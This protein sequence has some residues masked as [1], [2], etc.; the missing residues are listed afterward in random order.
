MS[1][2]LQACLI[3]FP[4]FLGGHMLLT[5]A[6]LVV[7]LV[8][9]LPL[10]IWASRW[11]LVAELALGVSGI[12]QTIPGLALLALMVPLLHGTIGFLPA[13]IAL[14]LYSLLP[15][16]ANTIVGIRGVD[17]SLTEAARGLG[18]SSRQ[19]LT[20]VELPLA[21]PVII[22]GIRTAAVL[23]VGT[24]TL[25]T[26]VGVSTLGSYIFSGL[27]L[28]NP[29]F[30]LF[31]CVTAAILAVV[32]DQLIHA[33]QVASRR[34]SLALALVGGFG[35]LLV[36]VGGL[37]APVKRFFHPPEKLVVVGHGP[38]TEQ[39]ILGELLAEKLQRSGF[40]PE[41]RRLNETILFESLRAGEID[42]YVEYTGNIWTLEM[43]QKPAD[44]ETVLNGV[45]DYLAGHGIISLGP[46]G[47]ENAYALAMTRQKA[48]EMN[49][50]SLAD[51]TDHAHQLRVGGDN[52]IFLRDEWRDLCKEYHLKFARQVPMDPTFMYGAVA[53]GKAV[54]IITAYTSDGRIKT[55]DLTILPEDDTRRVFP[56]YDAV[57][58]VSEKAARRPGFVEA[59]RPLLGAINLDAMRAANERADVGGILPRQVGVD[60]L[61]ALGAHENH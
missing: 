46:L 36:V 28:R 35:L 61:D 18:M 14:V 52:Q 1:E 41:N 4:E 10:G 40:H 47:F 29:F 13:F 54:D 56:P 34:R 49:V 22:S 32:I 11:R 26:P 24:A 58:L 7:G 15:I 55:F 6:G 9:S 21:A 37:Y 23:V 48:N 59:L 31:G 3:D 53:D 27:E 50:H 39:Y 44:R 8:L 38:F 33:L 2:N 42:C 17:P 43:K 19:M 30:T 60:M 20:R 25:A 5:V 16:V 51:L 12:I 45:R 57:L